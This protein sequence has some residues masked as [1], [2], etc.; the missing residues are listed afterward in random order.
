MSFEAELNRRLISSRSE[1]A[2][3]AQQQEAESRARISVAL[4][5][6]E[7]LEDQFREAAAFLKSQRIPTYPFVEEWI[8]PGFIIG[9]KRSQTLGQGWVLTEWLA[10]TT[11]GEPWQ[12]VKEQFGAGLVH[13]KD[14]DLEEMRN[15][16]RSGKRELR[17]PLDSFVVEVPTM[18]PDDN[19]IQITKPYS[20]L[21]SPKALEHALA[22]AVV[23]FVRR[24]AG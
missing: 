18:D 20:E 4:A 1:G 24:E 6:L 12:V 7:Q 11:T 22:E 14:W 19:P 5:A 8:A 23:D 21:F 9:K 15:V 10:L 17:L 13:S 3:H 2:Q 16:I